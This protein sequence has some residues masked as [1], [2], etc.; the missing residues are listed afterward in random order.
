MPDTVTEASAE[1]PAEASGRA[2]PDSAPRRL[3]WWSRWP[4]LAGHLA[5]AWS[6]LYGA[7]A[8][9]WALGGDGY[10]FQRVDEDRSSGSI[11]EPSR[12]EVVAPVL[13]VF[14]ALGVVAG[15][16]MVRKLGTGRVRTTLL[17]YG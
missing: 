12:A 2:A 1:T 10:P 14:C 4:D 8:L 6:A 3:R 5:V 17:A 11:L 9:Y 7:A 13:A 15:L 16:L